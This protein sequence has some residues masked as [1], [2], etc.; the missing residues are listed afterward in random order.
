MLSIVLCLWAISKLG[1]HLKT[2]FR[3][4]QSFSHWL[5]WSFPLVII[6]TFMDYH[7]F[8]IVYLVIL[9]ALFSICV[10]NSAGI[11]DR[12]PAIRLIVISI[13]FGVSIFQYERTSTFAYAEAQNKAHI[14]TADDRLADILLAQPLPHV[15]TMVYDEK[16]MLFQNFLYFAKK[17]KFGSP[18]DLVFIGHTYV[19]DSY[20][21]YWMKTRSVAKVVETNIKLMEEHAGTIA[22]AF[23]DSASLHNVRGFLADGQSVA[24]PAAIAIHDYLHNSRDWKIVSAVDSPQG[25]LNV[26]KFSPQRPLDRELN[27]NSRE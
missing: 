4:A 15:V 2:Y 25:L 24:L 12:Y 9:A 8:E 13:L 22:V 20:Y 18:E 6:C 27:E 1:S 26:Y 21:W 11:L 7:S 17:V 3:P 19:H 10:I 5:A 16:A 23:A 14:R